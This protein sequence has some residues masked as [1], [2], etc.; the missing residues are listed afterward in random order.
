MQHNATNKMKIITNN[1]K[2]FILFNFLIILSSCGQRGF[3][4]IEIKNIASKE[5]YVEGRM[6]SHCNFINDDFCKTQAKEK[7]KSY[8]NNMPESFGFS[9]WTANWRWSEPKLER[10][11]KFEDLDAIKIY[12]KSKACPIF[13]Y[14]K[15]YKG[16]DIIS[17]Y[18]QAI[19]ENKIIVLT[20]RG[21]ELLTKE[22][23]EGN[24]DNYV[25]NDSDVKCLKVF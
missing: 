4:N 6:R 8:K 24:K 19:A 12:Y 22:Q 25:I 3:V 17:L 7:F 23:Y 9:L 1:L 13:E 15:Y 10:Y 18:N 11:N 21:L 2:L 20:I 5:I 16:G 14:N